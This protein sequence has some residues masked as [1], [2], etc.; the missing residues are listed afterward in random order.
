MSKVSTSGYAKAA[1]NKV[2]KTSRTVA[3]DVSRGEKIDPRALS[4]LAP[5]TLHGDGR[6]LGNTESVARAPGGLSIVKDL[7]LPAWEGNSIPAWPP[8]QLLPL[9][10]AASMGSQSAAEELNNAIAREA[11]RRKAAETRA[12][13][14]KLARDRGPTRRVID[15]IKS[16]RQKSGVA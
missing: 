12:A 11:S 2:G 6:S 16:N 9:Q 5:A 8:Q 15:R 10:M 7:K 3:R 13:E 14:E 4:D 1:A